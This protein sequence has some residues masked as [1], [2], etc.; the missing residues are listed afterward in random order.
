MAIMDLEA[1]VIGGSAGALPV[2]EKILPAIPHDCAIPV[3]IVIHVLPT[4]PSLLGAV[5]G[6]H[7][8]LPVQ[9]AEDKEAVRGG[10]V[11]VAPPGYHLLIERDRTFALSVDEPVHYSRPAIDVLFESAADVYQARVAGV[12][13]SG[14]NQDGAHGLAVIKARGGVAVVQSP[15]DAS[16]RTMPDAALAAVRADHVLAT[17]GLAALLGGIAGVAGRG[18]TPRMGPR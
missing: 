13:L 2:L 6:A 11:Y 5:L 14:A 16:S 17:R 15:E 18:K 1:I 7:C 10:V 12:V 4:R 9:E 3:V 8:A